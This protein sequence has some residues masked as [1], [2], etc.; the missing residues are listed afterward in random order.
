MALRDIMHDSQNYSV[1]YEIL[2]EERNDT[3]VFLH[4]WGSNKEIMKQAFGGELKEFRLIFLDLPGFGNSSIQIPITTYD[5]AKIVKKFLNSLS[6]KDFSIVAHSFGGKVATLLKPKNLILLSSAGI[7]GKKSFKQIIL[8]KLLKFL[9]KIL[10]KEQYKYFKSRCFKITNRFLGGKDARGMSKTMYKTYKKVIDEDFSQ[11]FKKVTSKTLILWGINDRSTPL[12]SGKK[13]AE[14]I[15]DSAFVEFNGD[16]F[17]FLKH[18]KIIAKKIIE[19][20]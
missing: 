5:Y 8:I 15:E 12:S 16:H 11:N 2:N 10:T 19:L 18:S 14:L 20:Y 17:F 4:G 3:I 6:V 1:S 13:I 9:E 7:L